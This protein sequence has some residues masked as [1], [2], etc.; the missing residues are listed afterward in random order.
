M[1]PVLDTMVWIGRETRTWGVPDAMLEP[2]T[3]LPVKQ[4]TLKNIILYSFYR[5]PMAAKTPMN[6]RTA[7]PAKTLIQTATNEFLRRMRNTSRELPS[8]F[9]ESIIQEYACDLRR[10]GFH[11]GWVRLCLESAV[12]GYGRKV[13]EELRGGTLINR[14]EHVGRRG[15]LLKKL[16]GKSTWFCKKPDDDDPGTSPVGDHQ[17][18][19]NNRVICRRPPPPPQQSQNQSSLPHSHLD[20]S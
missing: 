1:M 4:G 12:K 19:N 14:P 11:Q 8:T 2:D 9:I 5:K 13:R 3:V 6:S 10:G 15:R 18:R 7:A 20:G 17:A 16:T